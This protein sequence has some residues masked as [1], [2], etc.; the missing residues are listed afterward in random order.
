MIIAS[1]QENREIEKRI[2]I[3]PEIAKKYIGLGFEVSL[4]E[5]YGFH[6]GFKDKEFIDQGVKILKDDSEV[7]NNA[8]IIVQLGLMSDE[9]ISLIKENQ[10]LIGVFNPQVNKEK[11]DDLKNKHPCGRAPSPLRPA[12]LFG[13]LSLRA[14]LGVQSRELAEFLESDPAVLVLVHGLDQREDVPLPEGLPKGFEEHA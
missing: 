2:S 11:I 6:L 7:M 3:T 13:S 9:K 4:P 10:T 12:S 1:I 8:D 5:N 14:R